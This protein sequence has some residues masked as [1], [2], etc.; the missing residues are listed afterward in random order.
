MLQL[1]LC[2]FN[3]SICLPLLV[4]QATK[5]YCFYEN[6]SYWYDCVIRSTLILRRL[7]WN[8]FV[9]DFQLIYF[10][11]SK[12]WPTSFHYKNRFSVQISYAQTLIIMCTPYVFILHKE[13]CT[14]ICYL[15]I[16][17]WNFSISTIR[18][19]YFF[20]TNIYTYYTITLCKKGEGP[21]E[22]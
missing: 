19:Y 17:K 1:I 2:L 21:G 8:L 12:F 22:E 9:I 11:G 4:I 14:N 13:H 20:V 6:S 18:L 3:R 7:F 15:F 16:K 10:F 5:I